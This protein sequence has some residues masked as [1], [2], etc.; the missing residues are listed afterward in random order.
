MLIAAQAAVLEVTHDLPAD[1]V[2]VGP[3]LG[4][5]TVAE[6]HDRAVYVGARPGFP[7]RLTAQRQPREIGPR[8]AGRSDRELEKPA[9][10]G[11]DDD[12]VDPHQVGRRHACVV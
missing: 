8:L 4:F 9:R 3:D 11:V 10:E 1:R 6:P 12:R 2:Q 7:P 5:G